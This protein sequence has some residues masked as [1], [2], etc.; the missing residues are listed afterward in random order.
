MSIDLTPSAAD[1]K[2]AQDALAHAEGES[3]RVPA[4][5][6]H[7]QII[8]VLGI[9]LTVLCL[10]WA[11]NV[12]YYFG[13]AFYQEQFLATILGL[14]LAL[15]FN[16][17]NRHGKPHAEFSPI[18]FAL[19]ALGLGAAIWTAV[20]WEYLLQ[21]VSYRTPEVLVLSAII[22]LLVL[23][24]LRRCTG[25]GLLSVVV[26]FFL[27][28]TVA[29]LMPDALRGK[30]QNPEALLVYL[31]FDPSALY[32][33]PLVVGATIVIMFIW[34]GDLLI[35]SGGG[36]FF[37]DIAVALM[38]R[39]R[40]GPAKICVVG[41][42]LFGTIS[43]SA[44]SNVA[45]GVFTILMMKRSGTPRA[46]PA[47]SGGRPDWRPAHAAGDGCRI[48]DGRVHRDAVFHDCTARLFLRCLLPGLYAVDLIAG[49]QFGPQRSSRRPRRSCAKVGI[50]V[51]SPFSSSPCSLGSSPEVAAISSSL[52]FVASCSVATRKTTDDR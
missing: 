49:R 35:A 22:L 11:A 24:A 30:P 10:S 52:V 13:T 50:S 41:S 16:A 43:G 37:K 14:A 45:G 27:Y 42:A 48:P 39:K 5:P 20:G 28:A 38:G 33:A 34:L 36:E 3:I 31:A 47:R 4:N 32:G 44:V 18:D 6:I 19:G 29:H 1:I 21:D 46:T 7:K 26:G 40:A 51:R 2:A 8:Y 9:I 12:A 25:W 15:A 17:V 23:E